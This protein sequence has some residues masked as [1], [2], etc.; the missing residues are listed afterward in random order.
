MKNS[1][2][3]Y[4]RIQICDL[5]LQVNGYLGYTSFSPDITVT[6]IYMIYIMQQIICTNCHV[7]RLQINI[8]SIQRT[9]D[10]L[11]TANVALIT[12]RYGLRFIRVFG[13]RLSEEK[14]FVQ[15]LIL[16]KHLILAREEN[17]LSKLCFVFCPLL[18][19]AKSKIAQIKQDQ[20]KTN[21]KTL[22]EAEAETVQC[23]VVK[24]KNKSTYYSFSSLNLCFLTKSPSQFLYLHDMLYT[25]VFYVQHQ[26]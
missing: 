8:S 11:N 2:S 20:V 23:K 16:S 13:L 4:V 21:F 18:N 10:C 7:F 24:E 17:G 12:G 22:Q 26:K 9:Y 6:I 5:A 15:T 19:V 1:E 25:K 14:Y 3:F